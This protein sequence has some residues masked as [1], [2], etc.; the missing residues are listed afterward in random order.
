MRERWNV[1]QRVFILFCVLWGWWLRT[2][3]HDECSIWIMPA[4]AVG[5][6]RIKPHFPVESWSDMISVRF[7]NDLLL[8]IMS[9][10]QTRLAARRRHKLTNIGY[11]PTSHYAFNHVCVV[12]QNRCQRTK[13][14]IVPFFGQRTLFKHYSYT[15][16]T[17]TIRYSTN[18]T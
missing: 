9:R 13:I 16:T 4:S 18:C 1:N 15:K 10:Q 3:I 11:Y 17:I 12:D 7:N 14:Y 5:L 2:H 8:I 6:L